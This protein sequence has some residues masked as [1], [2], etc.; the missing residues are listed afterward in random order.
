MRIQ[1]LVQSVNDVA[2]F[3]QEEADQARAIRNIAT[4]LQRFWEPSRRKQLMEYVQNNHQTGLC[5]LAEKAVCR[6]IKSSKC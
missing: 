6:L 2:A 4:H 5:E 1:R 3:F